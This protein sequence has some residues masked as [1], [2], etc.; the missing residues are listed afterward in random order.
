MCGFYV[1]FEAPMALRV[2]YEPIECCDLAERALEWDVHTF[3]AF[4][5]S[6][7]DKR[8]V[9]LHKLEYVLESCRGI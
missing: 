5:E 3:A 7:L 8:C 4:A 2:A 1:V 6:P 9:E